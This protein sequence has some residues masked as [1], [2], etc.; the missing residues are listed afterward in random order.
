M[1]A[2]IAKGEPRIKRKRV[3]RKRNIAAWVYR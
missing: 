3:R 2:K 1:G